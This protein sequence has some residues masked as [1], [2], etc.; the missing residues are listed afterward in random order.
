[1]DTGLTNTIKNDGLHAQQLDLS[2][3]F[4]SLLDSGILSMLL[5]AKSDLVRPLTHSRK[6]RQ[7]LQ[8]MHKRAV[9]VSKT[10]LHESYKKLGVVSCNG[11]SD[12]LDWSWIAFGCVRH[13]SSAHAR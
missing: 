8:I 11:Y 12:R 1:M 4:I 2:S 9:N 5:F 3:V 13:C 7:I 10:V 6:A